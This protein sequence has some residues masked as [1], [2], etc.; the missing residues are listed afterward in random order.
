MLFEEEGDQTAE[1]NGQGVAVGA[2][3]PNDP[4]DD[5]AV[6]T[7]TAAQLFLDRAQILQGAQTRYLNA[8][9]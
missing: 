8:M 4:V 1:E 7:A 5:G 3:G 2:N 6:D 9:R